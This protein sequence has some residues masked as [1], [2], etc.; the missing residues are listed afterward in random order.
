MCLY[1]NLTATERLQKR[2]SRNRTKAVW[3]Y[4]LYFLVKG[5][6]ESPYNPNSPGGRV[7][8]PGWVVSDSRAQ[9]PRA[10]AGT[11]NHGCHVFLE[12]QGAL[13]MRKN[14][15]G[16]DGKVLRVQ[17]H[18]KD[19]VAASLFGQAVFTRV[20]VPKASFRRAVKG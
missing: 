2:L 11:V 8:G 15:P 20:F 7:A 6:L 1:A 18:V 17:G 4:K 13:E 16:Y 5:K 14:W 9:K 12:E 19:F 3:A 10:R